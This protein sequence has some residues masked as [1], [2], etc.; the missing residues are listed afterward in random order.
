MASRTCLIEEA[1]IQPTFDTLLQTR[2]PP[3]VGLLLG[4]LEVGARDFI[5][6]LVPAPPSDTGSG[7]RGAGS[8]PGG[9]KGGKGGGS[10]GGD[11]L[12][13]DEEW[14]IEHSL[15]VS[16]MLPGGV[17]IVGLYAFGSD[18]AAKAAMPALHQ[19]GLTPRPRSSSTQADTAIVAAAV[20][21]QP[22]LKLFLQDLLYLGE[23]AGSHWN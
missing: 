12:E 13:V 6:A 17:S 21:L 14:I 1:T 15:Q 5:L 3:Q 4:K 16:R 20:S 10:G 23:A 18:A 19:A 11:K 8:S 2:A 9:G 22:S 7:A